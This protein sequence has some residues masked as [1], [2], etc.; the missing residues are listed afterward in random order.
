[1]QFL[2]MIGYYR[3]FC[4]NFSPVVAPLTSLFGSK[5]TFLWSDE[6]DE[7]FR[8][9]KALLCKAPVVAAPYGVGAGAVLL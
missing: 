2:G 6:C 1:M 8:S 9:A 3:S 4:I 5:V 7:A